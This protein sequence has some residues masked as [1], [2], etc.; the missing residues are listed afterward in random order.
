MSFLNKLLTLG[1]EK[2]M[3]DYKRKVD[4]INKLEEPISKLS[5]KELKAKTNEFRTRLDHGVSLD[6]LLPEAFACVREASKRTLGMRHFDVQLI[7]GMALHDGCIAEMRTGEGKTL[8][9]SLAGY[10]N[11]LTGNVHI[12]TVNE[13]LAKR[14]ATQMSQIYNFLGMSVGLIYSGMEA[15]LRHEA[16]KCDVTYGTNSEFGF[17]YLRDNMVAMLEAKVQQGH[18]FCIIDEADS[19][20]IDEARTPLIISGDSNDSNDKYKLFANGV[21]GM[22]EH[23]DYIKDES[24]RTIYFTEQG[25]VKLERAVGIED[26]YADESGEDARYA[27]CALKAEYLFKKD[28][29]YVVIDNEVKIVDEFTGRIMEGR[30][31]SEGLHQAVE[32]KENL[33]INSENMTLATVTLQNYFRLY[34]KLSGM[35][36]T[37][38]TEEGEFEKTYNLGVVTIPTNKPIIRVDHEDYVYRNL[39]LKFNA[40]AEEIKRRHLKGQPVLV[41]T[42]SIEKSER[43]SNLLRAKGIKH[44]VLNAKNYAREAAIIAQAG[45]KGAVTIA[46]NMAGRGTDII[47]GGNAE[48][49]LRE[50]IINDGY[51]DIEDIDVIEIE[52]RYEEIK[53][54]CEKEQEEVKELGG[55]MVIGTD[56]HESRRIDNQLKGRAGRQGDPGET[57]FYLSLED[58]VI[59][60]FGDKRVNLI[61]DMLEKAN[62]DRLSMQVKQVSKAVE[63]AQRAVEAQHQAARK[64]VLE[65][66]DVI[67]LQR[68]TIYKERDLLLTNKNILEKNNEIVDSYVAETIY[69]FYDGDDLVWDSN[70]IKDWLRDLCNEEVVIEKELG[71][72]EEDEIVSILA[73]VIKG[74]LNNSRAEFGD[75]IFDELSR[76]SMLKIMDSHWRIHLSE[77]DYLKAGI[78]LRAM[79]H[80][81]PLVEYKNEAFESFG[82]MVSSI[83]EDYLKLILRIKPAPQI[84]HEIVMNKTHIITFN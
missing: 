52:K 15:P 81:D 37:A 38:M 39:D 34:D 71:D 69:R 79:G 12:I 68:K 11:A 16:Y 27:N 33:K 76:K 17:D 58:D 42:I 6:S 64:N 53:R 14:D 1:S 55:L 72:L 4:E 45:R 5:D 70:S 9:A 23:I 57:Q 40:V 65:Y 36:G 61:S 22:H 67:D 80:R 25:I 43:L 21:K 77:M 8:V 30:R 82:E 75:D 73:S 19:I 41:G 35:S 7:G 44:E 62:E 66:D 32:A 84:Q 47:L 63:G 59:R 26:L 56:R 54:M 74:M 24:K 48:D 83:Y 13:Y 60:C 20:L 78:N 50:S 28:V 2:R 46:T 29:D 10:L 51:E 3:N 31:W 49:I 18:H